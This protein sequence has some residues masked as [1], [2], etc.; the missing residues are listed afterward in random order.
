MFC[1]AVTKAT[2]GFPD[3]QFATATTR[4]AINHITGDTS[5]VTAG[6]DDRRAADYVGGRCWRL[7][8]RQGALLPTCD[9]ETESNRDRT[10]MSP[11]ERS[12]L[13]AQIGGS[14]KMEAV[15]ASFPSV[16]KCLRMTLRIGMLRGWYVRT[17]GM[18]SCFLALLGSRAV[19]R[20][21]EETALKAASVTAEE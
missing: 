5:M 11:T 20:G 21:I 1:E 15:A 18:R 8:R 9:G 12:R 14:L 2:L 17:R 19:S 6:A 7:A 13:N 16:R 10:T 4:N 3:V